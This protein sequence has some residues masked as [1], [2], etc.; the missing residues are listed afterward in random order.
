MDPD[1]INAITAALAGPAPR[2]A[3]DPA[4][5]PGQG[6]YTGTASALVGVLRQRSAPPPPQVAVNPPSP[7][8]K[9]L[10]RL[11]AMDT[12]EFLHSSERGTR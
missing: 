4:L 9:L 2:P 7:G 10:Q 8:A 6:R 3:P 1:Y 11:A 5:A 12:F